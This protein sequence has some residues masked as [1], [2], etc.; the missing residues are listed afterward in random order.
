MC[1][2]F[3]VEEPLGEVNLVPPEGDQF[4][5]PEGMAVGNCKHRGVT[6]TVPPDLFCRADEL[7]DLGGGEKLT[8]PK[9]GVGNSAR[10]FH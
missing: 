6:V 10:R 8:A 1:A 4:A 7:F 9:L 2:P 3:D 5:D